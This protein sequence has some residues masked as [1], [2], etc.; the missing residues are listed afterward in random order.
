MFA[1]SFLMSTE[2]LISTSEIK[3]SVL[4]K[5]EDANKAVAAIHAK[6]FEQIG[7]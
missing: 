3:I 7:Q 5:K 4:I 2:I 1:S 6:F